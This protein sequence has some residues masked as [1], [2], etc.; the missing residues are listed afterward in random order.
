MGFLG[1]IGRAISN[2]AK[3]VG[4]VAGK[5][6]NVAG[7]VADI[8]GKAVNI[9]Q[10]PEKALGDFVK[11]AAGGLLDKLP[12]NLG[13]MIKPFA[14]KVIDGGLSLLSK[15]AV[16]SVFEFAKKLA[17]N[18]SKLADFAE[19]VKSGAEK[20]DAFADNVAGQASLS[21]VQN[22]FSAAQAENLIARYAA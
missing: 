19:A 22:I 7:K 16:G 15:S 8:A 4:D 20:V 9:L 1:G 14:E 3:T 6:A 2:V 5:V 10:N 13:N 18:V 21:N 11:K 12:F 17:P